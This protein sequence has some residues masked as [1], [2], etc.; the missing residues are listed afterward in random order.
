MTKKIITAIIIALL[1]N[2][3]F[4]RTISPGYQIATWPGFRTAA[5]SY[6]FDDNCSN[7]LA[8]AVPLF[9]QHNFTLTLFT[10]TNWVTDW[11]ALANAASKG[12]EIA[13][14]TV[15]H[16][17]MNTL[18][19]SG[20]DS[21][22][23][24][25][26]NAINAN[27]PGKQ[28]VTVA[29]P[30]C[31]EPADSITNKYYVAGRGC[32]GV[33]ENAIP[34]QFFNIS[35]V[36]CGATGSY[37][38]AQSLN[39]LASQAVAKGGWCVYLIHGI[40]NDGG[41]SPLLSSVLAAHIVHLDSLKSTIW[42]CTFGNAVRYIRE[43]DSSSVTELSTGGTSITVR[44]TE[45]LDTSVYKYPITVRRTL[46]SGWTQVTATQDGKTINSQISGQYVLFDAVPNAGN[47]VISNGASFESSPIVSG[48]TSN[49]LRIASVRRKDC[50][51][52]TV[53]SGDGE[54]VRIALFDTRGTS[55]LENVTVQSC[56]QGGRLVIPRNVLRNGTVFLTASNSRVC[57]TREIGIVK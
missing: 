1:T 22:L 37:T 46:P 45:S 18:S 33:V 42:V 43:R 32:S 16:T 3:G 36:V 11:T 31:I 9:N 39:S 56:S 48:N 38:T 35:S 7:Q 47:V 40:D 21:E 17:A 57:T 20:Q 49:G 13:S 2:S 15:T 14:H 27:V 51:A 54:S 19:A 4:G 44:I 26:Q 10:V 28:C 55:L 24:N 25:S 41:Y 52:V 34:A 29:Y 12:H 23:K 50:I 8:V 6:T 30:N 53:F 5:V